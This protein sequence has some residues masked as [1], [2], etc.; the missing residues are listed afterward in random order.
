MLSRTEMPSVKKA[1][2]MV[3]QINHAS[4]SR[5]KAGACIF[6]LAANL[7]ACN[8]IPLQSDGDPLPE[9]AASLTIVS[10]RG[11]Q[12]TIGVASGL[13]A[14]EVEAVWSNGSRD[15]T[16][17]RHWVPPKA[18]L[19]VIAYEHERGV[20]PARVQSPQPSRPLGTIEREVAT[21]AFLGAVPLILTAA[22]LTAPV[23]VP[24][25]AINHHSKKRPSENCCFI[26][27][28]DANTGEVIAGTNPWIQNA[29][30]N[31]KEPPLVQPLA[32][33]N[34]RTDR[35]ERYPAPGG[36]LMLVVSTSPQQGLRIVPLFVGSPSDFSALIE[37]IL[38]K[39]PREALTTLPRVGLETIADARADLLTVCVLTA[40]GQFVELAPAT[41][42]TWRDRQPRLAPLGVEFRNSAISAL[43][44]DK[45]GYKGAYVC[46]LDRVDWPREVRAEVRAFLNRLQP[47]AA[48]P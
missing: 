25:Y 5:A 18:S 29:I 21:M 34:T 15:I 12:K 31:S 20:A 22:I 45:R 32:P 1:T 9:D 23:W 30:A 13:T 28:E 40:D 43:G 35:H 48:S 39:E 2:P 3:A 44:E 47:A 16:R 10:D 7:A 8:S 27:I 19:L 38:S 17:F 46:F 14:F 6:V 26:W 33:G 41:E 4:A 24:I 11:S 36:A 42:N 37:T